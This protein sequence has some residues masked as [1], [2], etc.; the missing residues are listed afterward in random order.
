[1]EKDSIMNKQF[2][3][4]KLDEQF[5]GIDIQTVQIIE[6]I[7]S[8]MRVPK[9]PS[10]VKGVMNL[11]GEIIPVVD[12]RVK[13]NLDTRE[14]DDDTRIIIVKVEEDMVGIIV[15]QVREVIE[16]S[17]DQIEAIPN[18]QDKTNANYIQG[19]GKLNDESM[20]VTLLNLN[21]IIEDAFKI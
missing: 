3:V 6:R 13:F 16:L 5:Y 15:D 18:M 12:M 8:I 10:C 21:T 14:Y 11:R 9:A 7:K 20:I 19:V 4:F 2:V 1:M 17:K